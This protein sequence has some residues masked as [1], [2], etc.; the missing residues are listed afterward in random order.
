LSLILDWAQ[1]IASSNVS[2]EII[3]PCSTS[4]MDF[5]RCSRFAGGLKRYSVSSCSL[6]NISMSWSGYA[7]FRELIKLIPNSL[8]LS[9]YVVSIPKAIADSSLIYKSRKL[10][11]PFTTDFI[12]ICNT[13]QAP[14]ASL[15]R[16]PR[17]F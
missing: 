5:S 12:L 10:I 9:L 4:L 7:F 14:K 3:L 16:L 1:A 2:K 17:K 15:L 6:T 8:V 13:I 11:V